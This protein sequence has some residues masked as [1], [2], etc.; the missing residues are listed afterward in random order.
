M[1]RAASL[2]WHLSAIKADRLPA[3]LDGSGIKLAILDDGVDPGHPSLAPAYDFAN[4]LD[5]ASRAEDGRPRRGGAEGDAHGTAVAGLAAA[6]ADAEAGARGVAPAATIL[7]IRMPFTEIEAGE[8]ENDPAFYR[9][10]FARAAQADI[11]NNSW[12]DSTG[13]YSLHDPAWRGAF[14]ALADAVR[15]GRGGLGTVFLFAA[16]NERKERL[17]ANSSNFTNVHETIAVAAINK[18]G[19]VASYS[20]PGA[21]LLVTA[22]AGNL[23]TDRPGSEGYN[24][25]SGGDLANPDFTRKF[26]GT[27]A[28][29]PVAAGV[30]ALLLEA[31]PRLG[32]RDVKEILAASARRLASAED[33]Q[34][35]SG[36]FWNGGGLAMSHDLGGGL[37]DAAAALRLAETWFV[38]GRTPQIEGNV[39]LETI[40]GVRLG[41]DLVEAGSPVE[42]RFEVTRSG[43]E[44]VQEIELDLALTHDFLED[45]KITL[46]S[47]SGVESRLLER[48][49]SDPASE[50]KVA[51]TPTWRFGSTQ[52]WGEDPQGLWV[53][54]IEDLAPGDG[55]RVGASTLRLFGPSA[56]DDDRYLFTNDAGRFGPLGELLDLSGSDLLDLAATSRVVRVDLEPGAV[57]RI[58]GATLRLAAGT[59]IE[60]AIGGAG[61]DL[62]FGNDAANRLVGGA[63]RDRLVGRGGDDTLV[64]GAGHDRIDGGPGFDTLELA[65]G[66]AD[67]ALAMGRRGLE[68]RDLVGEDGFDRVVNVERIRFADATVDLDALILAA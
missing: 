60:G 62:L 11:A 39:R 50:G 45:L 22:P 47:P 33:W 66:R 63:G 56:S 65:G 58:A 35:G 19:S 29:T 10:A 1:P 23:T 42:I 26:G 44:R 30:V 38:E 32:Y 61:N 49:P 68:I 59:V 15:S 24:D 6:R 14:S 46:R 17:D 41:S 8:L 28:A 4:D 18:G 3:G 54:R 12:G 34:R 31:E 20:T 64:P 37:I 2:P 13:I 36:H 48:P 43:L 27:S 52:H 40:A 51:L 67:Y 25:G 16:G 21:S 9:T 55:G 7:S 5:V 57:S 53:L